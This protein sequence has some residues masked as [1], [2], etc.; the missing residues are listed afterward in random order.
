[1]FVYHYILAKKFNKEVYCFA[2]IKKEKQ[3]GGGKK[4]NIFG[5][6]ISNFFAANEFS[7]KKDVQQT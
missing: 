7:K 5:N 1:M 3:K 4:F 6:F 2:K